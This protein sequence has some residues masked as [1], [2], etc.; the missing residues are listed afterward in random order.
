MKKSKFILITTDLILF[1]LLIAAE[2]ATKYLA[3]LHLKNHAAVPLI[4][5]VLELRYLEN[6]GAAFGML[7]NQKGF[8]IFVAVIILIIF[9]YILVRTPVRKKYVWG[10][11]ALIFIAAGGTGN[12]MDR[13]RLDYVVDFIYFSL[14][15]FPIFN[16]ADIFVTIGTILLMILLLF[17]YK[18]EDLYFLSFKTQ[19]YREVKELEHSNVHE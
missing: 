1:I 9:T 6:S 4:Y 14:I 5:G 12:M 16:V 18:E 3:V 19:K 15:N 8:L 17:V 13:I 11:V 2:Q 7:Q 10:H